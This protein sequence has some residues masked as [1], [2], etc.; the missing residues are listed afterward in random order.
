MRVSIFLLISI[1]T[2]I[3]SCSK[4]GKKQYILEISDIVVKKDSLSEEERKTWH[5]KDIVLDTIPGISLERVYNELL[6]QK[7]GEEI[8]VAVIDTKLDIHHED[9][10]QSIWKNPNEIPGNNKDDDNN[11]YVDDING[12]NFLGNASG[13]DVV[14]SN[15]ESMRI[16]RKYESRFKDKPKDSIPAEYQKEYALYEGAKKWRAIE[17]EKG[18]KD[19]EDSDYA[20]KLFA[21]VLFDKLRKQVQKS[22]NKCLNP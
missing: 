10:A 8:I 9:I 20:A 18:L 15:F 4:D 1:Y 14:Y 13:E 3:L 19:K 7:E 2:I 6:D 5:H 22:F 21:L 17:F 12:W 16:I 11:G